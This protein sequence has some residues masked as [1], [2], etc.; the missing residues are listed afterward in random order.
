MSFRITSKS[1]VLVLGAS[2][3]VGLELVDSLLSLNC[4][5]TLVRKSPWGKSPYRKAGAK[6]LSLDLSNLPQKK[7][8]NLV[9][10]QDIIFHLAADTNV[11]TDLSKEYPF[12][13]NQVS[14]LKR[15]LGFIVGS[16]TGLIY[17]S[18]CSVYGIESKNV[19]T[20]KSYANPVTSYDL[21]KTACDQL[22]SF[23]REVYKVPCASLRFSNIYGSDKGLDEN[24]KNRRVINKM[25]LQMHTKRQIRFVRDGK[26]YRNY[27]HV[28]DAANM[29][30]AV[31]SNLHVPQDIYIACSNKNIYFLDAITLLAKKYEKS[32][33]AK[34]SIG[35]GLKS[36]YITD[37]RSFKLKPSLFFKEKFKY[38]YNIE[39]G[40]N[41]LIEDLEVANDR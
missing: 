20:D 39:S 23:Y 1:R 17:A 21:A 13:I 32:F 18:S 4:Q 28:V 8:Q 24:K 7:L 2:G 22:I 9:L 37:H 27:L 5:M 35:Q 34:I 29:L 12:Y 41:A 3:Q 26:F 15:M 40:F 14:L 16:D 33:N 6:L 19:V 38:K 30:I 10:D 11:Q 36:M 25:L 31:C